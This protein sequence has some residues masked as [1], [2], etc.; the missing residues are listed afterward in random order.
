[1]A[2]PVVDM[3]NIKAVE[4]DMLSIYYYHIKS[5]QQRL[6][7][8]AFRHGSHPNEA[9]TSRLAHAL[10]SRLS[11]T[12]TQTAPQYSTLMAQSRLKRNWHEKREGIGAP[13]TCRI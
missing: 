12:F 3:V 13:R 4:I 8:K 1:V 7:Y 11:D 10:H 9:I 5:T 2:T 6:V